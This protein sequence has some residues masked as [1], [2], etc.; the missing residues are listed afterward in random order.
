MVEILS[1]I[2]DFISLHIVAGESGT[3]AAIIISD[4]LD[5]YLLSFLA[6]VPAIYAGL[7]LSKI[8]KPIKKST[9]YK[10]LAGSIGIGILFASFYDLAKGTAGLGTGTLRNVTDV[11]NIITFSAVLAIF[12]AV[13]AYTTKI[14]NVNKNNN[15]QADDITATTGNSLSSAITTVSTV[16]IPLILIYVWSIFGVGSHSIGEGIIMGYDFATGSTSLSPAQ[17]SSFILHK[18]GEG[19]TIGV[20]LLF[21]LVNKNRYIFIT[22]AIAGLPTILG[23]GAGY[24]LFPPSIA[25]YF[26]AAAVGATISIIIIFVHVLLSTTASRYNI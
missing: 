20:L 21:S 24:A 23:A 10:V 7:F 15:R 6:S 26:F 22:G 17:I 19:F 4:S 25:T 5:V 13:Y 2:I 9:S 8:I 12:I 11:L 14:N 18:I 16:T 1:F 3:G